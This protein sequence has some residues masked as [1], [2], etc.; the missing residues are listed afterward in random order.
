M[1]TGAAYG[2]GVYTALSSGLAAGYCGYNTSAQW[3]CIALCEVALCPESNRKN[4]TMVVVPDSS[5][6]SL[7]FL[8]L[9]PS[10][11]SIPDVAAESLRTHT[12]VRELELARSKL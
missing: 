11:R 1:T 12:A 3:R 2:P 10:T 4:A 8:L 9:Y 7:R 6:V 5:A